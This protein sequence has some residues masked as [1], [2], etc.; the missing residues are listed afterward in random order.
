MLELHN[1]NGS[2]TTNDDWQSAAHPELIPVSL[3][4]AEPGESAIHAVLAPGHYTAVV[5]GKAA[6]TGVA[7][8]EAYNL[9]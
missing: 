1:A 7:L 3:Q 2:M 5:R 4:P 9:P 6:A 8:V